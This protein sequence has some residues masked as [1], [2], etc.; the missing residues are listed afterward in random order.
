MKSV[1]KG[2]TY[3]VAQRIP[4]WPGPA[5]GTIVKVVNL[6]GGFRGGA[7]RNVEDMQGNIYCVHISTLER[8]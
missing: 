5:V 4:L 2:A 6:P 7:I 1:R 3:R 8:I